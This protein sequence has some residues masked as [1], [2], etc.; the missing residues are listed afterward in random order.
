MV[1]SLHGRPS[2]E[3]TERVRYIGGAIIGRP[4]TCA[5]FH[6]VNPKPSPAVVAG[7][8]A[9]QRLHPLSRP[10]APR[11]TRPK[12]RSLSGISLDSQRSAGARR[13]MSP[14]SPFDVARCDAGKNYNR[15]CFG[16]LLGYERRLSLPALL[17][18]RLPFRPA[19]FHPRQRFRRSPSDDCAI[20]HP[21]FARTIPGFLIGR[22]LR[23]QIPPCFHCGAHPSAFPLAGVRVPCGRARPATQP[24]RR[25]VRA[26]FLRLMFFAVYARASIRKAPTACRDFVQLAFLG[27][28][29]ALRLFANYLRRY[30]TLTGY[31]LREIVNIYF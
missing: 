7:N 17:A 30:A 2:E 3:R 11:P 13:M 20:A 23:A 12:R 19:I 9:A 29:S 1:T 10:F 24:S 26:N 15:L 6:Y 21:T 25:A 31:V 16:A 18:V 22:R 28:S 27:G 5:V 8:S 4:S 14:R